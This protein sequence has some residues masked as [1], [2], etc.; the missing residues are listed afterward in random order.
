MCPCW[1][2]CVLVEGGVSLGVGFDVSKAYAKPSLCLLPVDQDVKLSVIAP[3]PCLLVSHRDDYGLTSETASKPSFKC[4]LLRVMVSLHSHRIVTKKHS[5]LQKR[6]LKDSQVLPMATNLPRIILQAVNVW[7]GES[8][9]CPSFPEKH[10][11]ASLST[12]AGTRAAIPLASLVTSMS[13]AGVCHICFLWDVWDLG[14]WTIFIAWSSRER[15]GWSVREAVR[16]GDG[17][18]LGED[19][20]ASL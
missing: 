14:T 12:T 8:G 16:G 15:K 10:T 2:R 19:G 18:G 20:R 5:I 1:S 6:K 11:S 9:L 7:C 3:A 17:A 4:F 13:T